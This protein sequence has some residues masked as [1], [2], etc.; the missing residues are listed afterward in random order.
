[1]NTP[2]EPKPALPP[3][4][5]AVCAPQPARAALLAMVHSSFEATLIVDATHHILQL[6]G[7]A[8]R[9]FG[10]SAR[11]LL[12]Q[13]LEVLLAMTSASE[14]HRHADG[15]LTKDAGILPPL[16]LQ[17]V[18]AN[19]TELPLELVLAR[20][21]ALPDICYQLTL[22]HPRTLPSKNMPSRPALALRASGERAH[23]VERR[24]FSRELYD[25]LGQNLGALKLNLDWLQHS[26]PSAGLQFDNR[27]QQMQ[28]VLDAIII[29]T[30]SIASGLRPPLLDD[31]GLVA[32]LQ[33][34]CQRFQQKTGIR[35]TLQ[36]GALP[37]KLGEP[38]DSVLFR[39]VQE[40]LLNIEQHAQASYVNL[41]LW[42]SG[43]RL[44]LLLHD[45]GCGIDP[46][47][48]R[49]AHGVGLAAMQQRV[50]ALD[51]NISIRNALPHG[52][53]ICV[54]VPLDS[55]PAANAS[56]EEQS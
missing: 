16:P 40:G 12:G 49:Q 22:R 13:S 29:R 1:M 48:R 35:C 50:A 38:V 19:G 7:A 47:R 45:N 8:E 36:H 23:E 28:Q 51:G 31:L 11:R 5:N 27:V 46:E 9:L 34:A 2:L 39:I 33:W 21:P 17:W 4:N 42:R 37:D 24:R 18:R 56:D 54:D 30:K 55:L 32:A 41:A 20:L 3:A 25:D 6:N 10:Y 44:H 26:F 43:S 15:V 14:Y 52:V 53:E